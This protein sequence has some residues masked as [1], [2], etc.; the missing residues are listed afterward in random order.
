MELGK[1]RDKIEGWLAPENARSGMPTH[2]PHHKRRPVAQQQV[3]SPVAPDESGDQRID[4]KESR[5][6]VKTVTLL[7]SAALDS[8]RQL[9]TR[10]NVVPT[11]PLSGRLNMILEL[12]KRQQSPEEN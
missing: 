4:A 1:L 7:G 2:F 8:V 5:F 11:R 12:E 3:L 6:S 9:Y 10:V